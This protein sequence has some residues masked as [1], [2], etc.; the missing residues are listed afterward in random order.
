MRLGTNGIVTNGMGEVL[1]IQRDDTRTFAPPGGGIEAGELPPDNVAREVR[2]ETGLIVMPVRLVG[3]YFMNWGKSGVLTFVFRCIQRGGEPTT[4]KESLQVGFFPANDLPASIVGFHR[5]R[6]EHGFSHNG[7]PP[8]WGFEKYGLGVQLGRLVLIHGLYRWRDWQR[9]RR[10]E[11]VFV[12]A[13]EWTTG[14]FTVIRNQKGEV[15]WVKRNDFDAWN[16]PGGGGKQKEAP[17]ETAVRETYEE[18]GLNVTLTDLTGVYIYENEPHA[19]FTFTADI[20]SGSLTTGPESAEF[21]WFMPGAEPENAFTS[22]VVRVADAV[23]DD[24]ITQFRH[25]KG[26]PPNARS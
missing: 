13:P 4:S 2:E 26:N 14:A 7:G 20:K 10:G 24:E 11:P 18:T 15:L 1:L 19:I 25:Q 3:L 17:W 6:I 9:K 8:Y 5:D 12:P 23:S 22:H 16:L 21:A